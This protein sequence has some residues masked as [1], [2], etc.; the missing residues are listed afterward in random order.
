MHPCNTCAE[1]PPLGAR[2]KSFRFQTC[3]C[4]PQEWCQKQ[5]LHFDAKFLQGCFEFNDLFA[6][7]LAVG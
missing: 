4:F 5:G 7:L 2:L 3:L 6:D 1:V